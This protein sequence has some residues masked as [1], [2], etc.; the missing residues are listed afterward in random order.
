MLP[1]F[2]LHHPEGV[3]ASHQGGAESGFPLPN[4]RGNAEA[5]EDQFRP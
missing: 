1:A 5:G 2:A 3:I 4:S